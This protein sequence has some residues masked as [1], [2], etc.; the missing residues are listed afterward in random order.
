MARPLLNLAHGEDPAE[1]LVPVENYA[2]KPLPKAFENF[3]EVVL[4]LLEQ[5]KSVDEFD[6]TVFYSRRK[7]IS[8]EQ[9][10]ALLDHNQRAY[11]AAKRADGLILYFQGYLLVNP[12][13]FQR[14]AGLDLKFNPD[15]MS[16]C[17]WE[18]L[19]LARAGSSVPQHKAAVSRTGEWY[20]GVAIKKYHVKIGRKDGKK[21][22]LF[23]QYERP[24]MPV[25]A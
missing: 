22:I 25:T 12:D 8:P 15:C 10:Q 9:H 4:P 19:E 6:V 24:P 20:D 18:S 5:V 17:I 16:F 11:D 14:D 1:L 23:E 2:L 13:D 7:G 3:D 21:K